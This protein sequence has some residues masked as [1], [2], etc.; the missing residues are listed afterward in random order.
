MP[1]ILLSLDRQVFTQTH[2]A[3]QKGDKDA[4]ATIAAMWDEHEQIECFVCGHPNVESPVFA[5]IMPDQNDQLLALPL[6]L[7]CR[8]L[9]ALIRW[10]KCLELMQ[11][12]SK[13]RTGKRIA[14][15][16]IAPQHHPRW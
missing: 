1:L 10:H 14:Y 9:P 7:I 13:A 8:A 4:L 3:A 6:C 16:R 11:K 12:M 5:E 15:T 2:K